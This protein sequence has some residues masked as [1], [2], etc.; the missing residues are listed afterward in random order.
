MGPDTMSP[1]P[2]QPGG[3]RAAPDSPLRSPNLVSCGLGAQATQHFPQATL[4][5]GSRP[6]PRPCGPRQ[7]RRW[8]WVPGS[9]GPAEGGG[10]WRVCPHSPRASSGD[11]RASSRTPARSERRRRPQPQPRSLGRPWRRG[12]GRPW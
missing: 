11:G 9:V 7:A 10:S 6:P 8:S 5:C 12:T 3:S 1:G 4:S 2:A